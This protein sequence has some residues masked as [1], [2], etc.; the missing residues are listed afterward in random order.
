[1]YKRQLYENPEILKVGQNI[2]YDYEVLMNYGIEIQ[3]KMFDTM[4]AHYL[5]QR[6]V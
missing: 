6:C 1:M 5:I 4:L 3:G 2:K